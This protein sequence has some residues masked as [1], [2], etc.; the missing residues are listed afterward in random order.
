MVLKGVMGMMD[1]AFNYPLILHLGQQVAP[2]QFL[3]EV[4]AVRIEN[5]FVA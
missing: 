4:A 3:I 1:N 2:E 5:Y